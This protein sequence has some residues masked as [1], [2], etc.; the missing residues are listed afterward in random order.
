VTEAF[1]KAKKALSVRNVSLRESFVTLNEELDI[2]NF[3][4]IKSEIQTFR[5]VNKVK[6]VSLQKNEIESFEYHFFYSCGIRLLN[7][8]DS[9]ITESE[10]DNSNVLVE[11]R[12]TFDAVYSAD[13]KVAQELLEA[14]SDENVGYHV[15]PYWRELVQSS[16]S[17][18]NIAPLETTL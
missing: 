3:E 1:E 12:A 9:E 13:K 2:N 8:A 4:N 16:C 7:E 15:W 18:F 17:R 14:Y 6:E 11:I 10:N 5:G